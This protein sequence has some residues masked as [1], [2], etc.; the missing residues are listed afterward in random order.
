[1]IGNAIFEVPL[2]SVL[3][4]TIV[5][6]K[7]PYPN[8]VLPGANFTESEGSYTNCERRIQSLHRTLLPSAGRENWEIISALSA[9]LGYPMDYRTVSDIQREIAKLVPVFEVASSATGQL[10]P[11]MNGGKFNFDDGLARLRLAEAEDYETMEA[12]S[13]LSR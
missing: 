12:L 4:D 10:W 11:L 9:A 3:M 13:H 7:P 6:D 5:P 2:F 1:M 8:V